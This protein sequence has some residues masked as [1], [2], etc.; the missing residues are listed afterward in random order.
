MI[1]KTIRYEGDNNLDENKTN[2]GLAECVNRISDLCC[3]CREA[4]EDEIISRLH[5]MREAERK[6]NLIK[7]KDKIAKAIDTLRETI[8]EA[9]KDDV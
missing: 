1:V 5:E 2:N 3:G 7:N 9:E 6:Y 8:E 4:S